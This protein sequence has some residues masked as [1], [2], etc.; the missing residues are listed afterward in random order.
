MIGTVVAGR[1]ELEEE[2]GVGGM[3]TVYRARD[4]KDGAS[5]GIKLIPRQGGRDEARFGM[6]AI[7]LARLSHPAIV[8]YVGHGTVG[9]RHY[10]A[11]EWLEGEDLSLHID[12]QALGLV[13]SLQVAR[14][15]AE[16]LVYAHQMGI[17][18]RDIKPS[19]L[20]LPGSRLD[21]LKVLDFGIARLAQSEH[22]LTK[23]GCFVGTPGYVAPEL[24]G[25]GP[26]MD[27]RADVFSLGCVLYHCLTGRSAFLGHDANA[28][29]AKIMIEDPASVRDLV[30]SIPQ[31][32]GHM[33]SRMLAKRIEDRPTAHE[34]LGILESLSDVTDIPANYKARRT[35]ASL[36]IS[37]QRIGCV[38]MAKVPDA[39]L[40]ENQDLQAT[41]PILNATVM[42]PEVQ[43]VLI[44]Q[45]QARVYPLPNRTVVIT[46]PP[47][48]RPTD[49]ALVAARAALLVRQHM[50]NT[51]VVI[52]TGL[53]SFS[54]R[55]ALGPVIDAA[56][57]LL[58]ATPRGHVRIDATMASFL[59]PRFEL[60]REGALT[61][62]RRERELFEPKRNL[63]GKPAKFVGRGQELTTLAGTLTDV[64]SEGVARAVL[65]TGAAGMGKSRLL[66]EFLDWTYKQSEPVQI[67]FGVGDSV[68]AGAPYAI[69]GRALCAHAGIKDGDI[70]LVRRE[71]LEQVLGRNL[72]PESRE[73]TVSFLGEIAGVPFPDV[74]SD[75]L[76]A[77]RANPLLM[78][79][80]TR[81]AWEDWLRAECRAQP[82][83]LILEDL[84]WG[85]P[86]TVS[87]VDGALRSLREQ[88]LMVLALARPDVHD[89]FPNLWAGRALN[90]MQLA[91]LSKRAAEQLIREALGPGVDAEVVDKLLGR[92]DGIPFYLEELVRAVHSGHV[93]NLPDS[94]FGMVQAR[95]D[96]EGPQ[97]KR[98]L[99]AAS[100]FGSRFSIAG[101]TAL[102][103]GEAESLDVQEWVVRLVE[104]ELLAHSDAPGAFVHDFVFSHALV[105]EAAYAM[106]TAEDR[107]LGH[108]LAGE[109]L[110]D[111]GSGEAML[112]AE[113]F[114]LGQAPA[115]AAPW[116]AKAAEQDLKANDLSGA[117][118]RVD[119]GLSA[120]VEAAQDIPT[121]AIA[122]ALMLTRTEVLLWQG[123]LM[124][125]EDAGLAALQNLPSGTPAWFRAAGQT[126]VALGK[127]AKLDE[128]EVVL[129]RVNNCPVEPVARDAALSCL[130]WAA[131]FLV[132]AG[133]YTSAD[134]LLAEAKRLAQGAALDPQA[135]GLLHQAQAA[136]A[137]SADELG[138]CLEN[139]EAGLAA[140]E[141][142]G[143]LRNACT[144]RS[145][146]GFFY[147]ELGELERAESLLRD[148]LA[149]AQ[150]LRL[151]EV[152][153]AVMHN[154]GRVLGWRG[155]LLEAERL[156]REAVTS[157]GEQGERRLEGLARTYLAEILCDGDRFEEAEAEAE[158]AVSLLQVS[159]GARAFALATLAQARLRRRSSQAA[160]EAS[161]GAYATL[162]ALG[163][164][165]EGE[166]TVRLVQ[167]EC[168]RA[169][170]QREASL[171]VLAVA[172]ERLLARA[173]RIA[174]PAWRSA[175]LNRVPANARTL[176]LAL[177]QA[178]FETESI[179]KA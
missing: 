129:T 85:D 3:G 137:S 81:R 42:P 75:V 17:I 178:Q 64:S 142:A 59:D 15:T 57:R 7:I 121:E 47:G 22:R 153:A 145:N 36:T 135:L 134:V 88:P 132:V 101:L 96:A 58:R 76:R 177:N 150:Q 119:L 50:P 72:P 66:Q 170:G 176:A 45:L 156:E 102:L 131:G 49:E 168:L 73:N 74:D 166:A 33:V 138:N 12:R 80:G 26:C 87:L 84:H 40:Q 174:L 14:R 43:A 171:Q 165:E 86:A 114:R 133:R 13:A 78:S 16:A 149:S 21:Q 179:T 167:A 62:L 51:S 68:A 117:L 70:P 90:V 154:L 31:A 159:S 104:R 118:A 69:L 52:A 106:L 46:F 18:H 130:G 160:L 60:H 67:F 162:Q 39:S 94:V 139:L 63:L 71:K 9:A 37:E 65:V 5:V 123:E 99:R 79:D 30:P 143:D 113:H 2:V 128:I 161:Q 175:F 10:L 83:L 8:K 91:P 100:I 27:G 108:R 144:I 61:F 19:N 124:E 82:V 28:L 29:I 164:L 172:R 95:L 48:K 125:A 157:F 155:D 127:Q 89:C 116:Y 20:F 146:M 173:A 122:G 93:D 24:V 120:L 112:V 4:L 148:A 163:T 25:G 53:G 77:A 158:Q 147:L 98:V 152:S 11:M 105:R 109:W 35:T 151:V 1:F 92:G 110:Q 97:A 41:Q 56:S 111:S 136:R 141:Q 55:T 32:V 44:S 103:G 6:E 115:K 23:T 140:F 38:I 107:V 34:L 126:I 54:V 169:H